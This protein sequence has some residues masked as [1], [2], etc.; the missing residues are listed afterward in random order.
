MQNEGMKNGVPGARTFQSAAPTATPRAGAAD[1]S[2]RRRE[3]AGR[4]ARPPG[5]ARA[6][7]KRPGTGALQDA[8]A[9]SPPGS[10]PFPSAQSAKS[11]EALALNTED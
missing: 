7:R 1:R 10:S 9:T 5:A 3:R 8:G 2:R 4:K 11:A 6:L